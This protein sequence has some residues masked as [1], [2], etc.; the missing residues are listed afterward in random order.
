M[1]QERDNNAVAIA[2]VDTSDFELVIYTSYLTLVGVCY[3]YWVTID[4]A[5]KP[6]GMKLCRNWIV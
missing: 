2:K 1:S 6:A 5:I 3:V 4:P